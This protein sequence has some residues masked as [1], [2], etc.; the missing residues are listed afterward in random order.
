MVNLFKAYNVSVDYRHLYLIGDYVTFGGMIKAMNRNW[1]NVNPSPFLRMTFETSVKYI[2]EAALRCE[3]DTCKTP[4]S[5]IILGQC[6]KI[7]TGLHELLME[8]TM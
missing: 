6:P 7:G 1:M 2:S 3:V 4:S 5:S 8:T